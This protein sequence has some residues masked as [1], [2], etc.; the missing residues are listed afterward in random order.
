MVFSD[1][2]SLQMAKVTGSV[3]EG[4]TLALTVPV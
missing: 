2:Y 3:D 1:G 4:F